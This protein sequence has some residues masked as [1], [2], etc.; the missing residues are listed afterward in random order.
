LPIC[1]LSGKFF[2]LFSRSGQ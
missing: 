2:R 1:T